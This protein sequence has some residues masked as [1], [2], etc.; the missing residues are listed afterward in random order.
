MKSKFREKVKRVAIEIIRFI[1]SFKTIAKWMFLYSVATMIYFTL[2]ITL[3]NTAVA[4]AAAVSF[5]INMRETLTICILL[6]H[7]SLY[8]YT[9]SSICAWFDRQWREKHSKN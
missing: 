2:C 8:A 4:N 5:L 7:Y 6:L 9:L 3:L 1:A